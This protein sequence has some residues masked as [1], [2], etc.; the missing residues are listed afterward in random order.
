MTMMYRKNIIV[1]LGDSQSDL[2]A[3]LGVLPGLMWT[4]QLSKRLN[5]AG[6]TTKP[7]VLA[8][9]GDT[10]AQLIG[11]HSSSIFAGSPSVSIIYAGVNDPGSNITGTAAAGTNN[12]INLGANGSTSPNSYVGNVISITSGTGIGQQK[13]VISYDIATKIA[14]VDSN[15]SVNPN[16]TSVYSISAPSQAQIQANHQALIKC[17]KYNVAGS[18]AGLVRPTVL[19]S[20]S[21]LPA[22]GKLGQRYVIMVDN[23]STGGAPANHPNQHPN[24]TSNLSSSPGQTVWEW[25]NPQSGENGWGRVAVTGTPIFQNGVSKIIS[26]GSN[27]LNWNNGSGDNFNVTAN[28]G[29]KYAPYA[30]VRSAVLAATV[31]EGTICCDLF[32]YMSMC[33]Y[34]GIFWGNTILSET[35]QGSDAWHYTAND[36]HHNEYGHD[37]V[38]RALFLTMQAQSGWFTALSS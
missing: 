15:W 37:L 27:Y 30:L 7:V 12:S 26:I 17:A 11:R 25:R 18:G 6:C 29:T 3:V 21:M 4:S 28:T 31:A 32:A 13:T 33:I 10:T 2:L 35:T 16:G 20:T 38:A 1:G 36:Q 23:S 5:I 14:I 9:S 8:R 24:I 22:N 19:W 34:G